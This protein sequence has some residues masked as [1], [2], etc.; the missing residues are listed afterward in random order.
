MYI[1]SGFNA[2]ARPPRTKCLFIFPGPRPSTAYGYPQ[3]LD[4]TWKEYQQHTGNWGADRDDFEDAVD[5]IGWY[6]RMSTVRCG[7]SRFDPYLLYLA[8]HEGHGGFNRGSY[9]N[10][11]DVKRAARSVEKLAG[12]YTSLLTGCQNELEKTGRGCWLWPF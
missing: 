4:I 10:K 3:A 11:T 6:C 9:Q 12:Q 7:I 2:D 1:E 8:Y 5:F